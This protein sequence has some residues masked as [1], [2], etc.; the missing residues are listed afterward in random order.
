MKNIIQVLVKKDIKPFKDVID[1]RTALYNA[2][3]TPPN[4]IWL[5]NF[6]HVQREWIEAAKAL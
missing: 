6:A 5:G 1:Y 4:Q 2:C 3:K